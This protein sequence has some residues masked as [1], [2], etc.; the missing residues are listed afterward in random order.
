MHISGD[1][2]TAMCGWDGNLGETLG[3]VVGSV[4]VPTAKHRLKVL[5]KMSYSVEW[6]QEVRK[7]LCKLPIDLSER[8]VLK[9]KEAKEDPFRYLEH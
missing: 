3:L 1:A 4:P 7:F 8:I 5:I 9:V 6:H 2:Q